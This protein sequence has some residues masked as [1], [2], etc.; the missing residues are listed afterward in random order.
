MPQAA[1]PRRR[2]LAEAQR[3]PPPMANHLPLMAEA[4][5]LATI[6][7]HAE[8]RVG[9]TVAIKGALRFHIVSTQQEMERGFDGPKLALAL[10]M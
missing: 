1:K 8:Q 2:R 6:P 9:E 7:I 10:S 4:P 3:S 5:L